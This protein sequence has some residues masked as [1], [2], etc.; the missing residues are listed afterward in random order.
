MLT[1]YPRH[2]K[3]TEGTCEGKSP[4]DHVPSEKK[5]SIDWDIPTN[6]HFHWQMIH[7]WWTFQPHL[8]TPEG[9]NL[10]IIANI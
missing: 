5:T 1:C 7:K 4:T 6:G 2:W 8:M 10:E 3:L 9:K